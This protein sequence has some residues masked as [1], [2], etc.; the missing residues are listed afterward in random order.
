M[1]IE[2]ISGTELAGNPYEAIRMLTDIFKHTELSPDSLKN[3]NTFEEVLVGV[4]LQK[5]HLMREKQ[6]K[7]GKLN[8]AKSGL[9]GLVTR[10]TD[11]LERMKNLIGDPQEQLREARRIADEMLGASSQE[12][13]DLSDQLYDVLNPSNDT[14]E[15]VEDTALDLGNYGDIIYMFLNDAWGFEM[16]DD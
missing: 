4:F 2:R 11:K 5:F 6:K 7:Y 1:D 3:L 15:S 10:A 14:N 9:F 16:E 13:A 8:I 12:L